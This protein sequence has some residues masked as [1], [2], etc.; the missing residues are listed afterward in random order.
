MLG[1]NAALVLA[2]GAGSPQQLLT[3][4]P[5]SPNVALNEEAV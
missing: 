3:E 4:L 5:W 1:V 2:A